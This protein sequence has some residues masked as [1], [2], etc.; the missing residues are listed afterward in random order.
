MDSLIEVLAV[1]MA[2]NGAVNAQEPFSVDRCVVLVVTARCA[3]FNIPNAEHEARL[4][5]AS[6]LVED[7][8]D[9][10]ADENAAL[11]DLYPELHKVLNYMFDKM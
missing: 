11:F 4:L 2:C 8:V 7:F 6:G 5:I 9:G 3:G 1:M 10:D